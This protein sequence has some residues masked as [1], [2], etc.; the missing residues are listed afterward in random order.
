MEVTVFCEKAESVFGVLVFFKLA[1]CMYTG[2]L[3]LQ[4]NAFMIKCLVGRLLKQGF[5][6][7]LSGS[8]MVVEVDPVYVYVTLSWWFLLNTFIYMQHFST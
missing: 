8:Y 5:V 4:L 3:P 1:V 6:A 7:Y 2:S